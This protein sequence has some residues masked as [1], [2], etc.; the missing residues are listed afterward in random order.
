LFPDKTA[1]YGEFWRRVVTNGHMFPAEAVVVAGYY[2]KVPTRQR[3]RKTGTKTRILI[4][5]Q[6][7]VQ[8]ELLDYLAFL[9]ASLN[10]AGW[11]ITIKPHP[12]EDA[13]PYEALAEA[14]FVSVSNRTAYELLAECDVHISSY[15]SVLYEA[16]L[17]GICNYALYVDRYAQYCDEVIGSGAALP[18]R[19]NQLP[20]PCVPDVEEARFYLDDYHP[21][22]LFGS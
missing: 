6:P 19:P 2:L 17:Y 9:K 8:P 16:I 5:T 22:V 4:C 1:V 3:E 20:A 10:R 18:L 14:G 15:S 7:T 12:R 21:G 13:A 11:E